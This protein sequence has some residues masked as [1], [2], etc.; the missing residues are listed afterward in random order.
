MREATQASTRAKMKEESKSFLNFIDN[1]LNHGSINISDWK[2]YLEQL[3]IIYNNDLTL[4]YYLTGIGTGLCAKETLGS[5]V[6]TI[7]E[8]STLEKQISLIYT[9]G[10]NYMTSTINTESSHMPHAL[11]P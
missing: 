2:K 5:I 11:Q 6:T 3:P 1:R 9:A 8:R 7:Q 4:N 10:K